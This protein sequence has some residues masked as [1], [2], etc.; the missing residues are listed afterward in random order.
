[1]SLALHTFYELFLPCEIFNQLNVKPI[2]PG[3]VMTERSSFHRGFD[4]KEQSGFHQATMSP[5]LSALSY[6]L[7]ALRPCRPQNF[8]IGELECL[9]GLQFL[10]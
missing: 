4:G 5:E 1:M 10:L 3:H 9:N 6:Q 8:H 2:Q 7:D